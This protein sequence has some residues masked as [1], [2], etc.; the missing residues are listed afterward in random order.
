MAW[1]GGEVM[2]C[3]GEHGLGKKRDDG[4]HQCSMAARR[5]PAGL[6]L[7]QIDSFQEGEEGPTSHPRFPLPDS[8]DLILSFSNPH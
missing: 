7:A 3:W 6:V 5:A 4:V 1:G 2:A 8:P